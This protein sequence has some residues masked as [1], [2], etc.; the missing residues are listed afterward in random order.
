MAGYGKSQAK[1]GAGFQIGAGDI[2]CCLVFGGAEN[3]VI[4]PSKLKRRLKSILDVNRDRGSQVGQIALMMAYKQLCHERVPPDLRDTGF[5]VH[6]QNEEDGLLLYI[7]AVIGATNRKCIEICCGD[8]IE[9]NCANLILNHR[10]IGMLVDGNRQN[11]SKAQEF[12][13]NAKDSMFWPP[14]VL[15]EWITAE[16]VN[17]LVERNG[18]GG[19]IDLL[20]LDLDGIDYW[21]WRSLTAASPRVVVLEF[22][23]LWGPEISVTVPYRPDFRA[24]LTQFGSDYAG[25]SLAAFVKLGHE[26]GYRLVGTNAI[27]TNALFVRN[28]IQSE[29]FPEISPSSCF[30]HPRARFGMQKHLP[31]VKAK[32][33]EAV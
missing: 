30:W 23:H 21:V 27:A 9:C 25:A 20:S 17:E 11:T 3:L 15:N 19:A 1:S 22:N 33:W 2:A 12:Y 13:E 29:W 28:D 14:V 24:E 32:S 10:W 18:F 5:R 6:S 8:G 26:K 4:T 16:N 31:G 7:F